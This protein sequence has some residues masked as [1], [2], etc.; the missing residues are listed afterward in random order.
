MCVP[1]FIIILIVILIFNTLHVAPLAFHKLAQ[2]QFIYH[3]LCKVTY[4]LK[5]CNIFYK[6]FFDQ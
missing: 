3:Y 1:L 4:A 2:Y 6:I 5:F